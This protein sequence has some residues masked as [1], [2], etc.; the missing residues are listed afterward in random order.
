MPDEFPLKLMQAHPRPARLAFLVSGIYLIVGV[1]WILVSDRALVAMTTDAADLTR[2][3]NLKGWF[4]VICTAMALFTGLRW[5]LFGLEREARERE[6]AEKDLRLMQG[7]LERLVAERTAQLEAKNRE[8]EEFT[9]SVSHDLKAPLRGI[10]GYSQL[11]EEDHAGQLPDEARRYIFTI[12]QATEQMNQLIDDLLTYSR[13][14]RREVRSQTM[15]LAD[16]VKQVL[17]GFESDPR[18]QRQEITLDVPALPLN[19]D[20]ESLAM[21][22]RNLVDN[23][24]KFTREKHS[25]RISIRAM[26]EGE[27][28]RLSVSDNGTGFDMQFHNRIFE[29]F[30]R[31]HRSEEYPGTGIGLALVRKSMERLGGRAWAESRLGEGA[32]FHLEFPLTLP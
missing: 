10:D 6:A 22:L 4:Y 30:Q 27:S 23:A 7:R 9:Y 20:I 5:A 26:Q 1:V 11:L 13:L 32:S 24:L 8:L 25:P 28:C 16:V 2:M 3:Q 12:R 18:R 29:I 15:N 21:A 14:E 31:L 19:T 17:A